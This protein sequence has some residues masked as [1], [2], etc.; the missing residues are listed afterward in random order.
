MLETAAEAGHLD[1]VKLIKEKCAP[2]ELSIRAANMAAGNGHLHVLKWMWPQMNAWAS[3]IG[4]YAVEGDHVECFKFVWEKLSDTWEVAIP[5]Q[6]MFDAAVRLDKPKCLRFLLGTGRF[7]VLDYI[8]HQLLV[9]PTS[10]TECVRVCV[11][12]GVEFTAEELTTAALGV[13][14]EIVTML[15]NELKVPWEEKVLEKLVAY[16]RYSPVMFA[17]CLA[18]VAP[19]PSDLALT[20]CLRGDVSML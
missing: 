18:L 1:C 3:N 9:R 10:G 17:H 5:W 12:H 7:V 13:N 6:Q 15:V 20:L 8:R 11:E 2:A 19:A 14:F 16:E 4:M